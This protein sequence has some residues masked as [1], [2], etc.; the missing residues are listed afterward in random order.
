MKREVKP[1]TEFTLKQLPE[2]LFLTSGKVPNAM[3]I[4]WGQVGIM[5]RKKVFIA[6]VRQSRYTNQ[7]MKESGVFTV[8]VPESGKM[9]KQLGFCGTKSGRDV[10]KWEKTGLVPIKAKAVDTSVVADCK[11]YYE[12]KIIATVKLDEKAYT[13]QEDLKTWY[14]DGDMHELFI[15]EIVAEY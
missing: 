14:K 7:L 11:K 5:W 9:K 10:D 12:C 15:G 2:G 8:S 4:G 13:S 1:D 3:T 6:P